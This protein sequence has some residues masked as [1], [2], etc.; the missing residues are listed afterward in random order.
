MR[1]EADH[2]LHPM[3]RSLGGL[4]LKCLGIGLDQDPLKDDKVA[5]QAMRDPSQSL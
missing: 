3:P 2:V 5:L 4:G 1:A